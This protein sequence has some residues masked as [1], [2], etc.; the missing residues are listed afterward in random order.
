MEPLTSPPLYSN[1]R[2][3]IGFMP[4][5]EDLNRRILEAYG[6][7]GERDLLRR[8]HFFG[9]RYENVYVERARI[10][11]VSR[12]LD[13][14]AEYA[15]DI[16]RRP[17]QSL[18][19]GFWLNDM[20]PGH[21]TTEHTHEEDDELLSGVYYVRVPPDSGDLM[22]LDR[23]IRTQ[24]QPEPGMFVFFAPRVVHAVSENRSGERRLSIGINFGPADE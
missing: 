17:G 9:G 1:S 2:L 19:C 18:R 24:V 21:L 15:R 3:H 4:D 10:P 14:A 23:R 5:A 7:L 11:E 22:I 8:T 20:G 16:L 6:K 12:I 13:C